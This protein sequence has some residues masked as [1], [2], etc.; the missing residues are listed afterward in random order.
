VII[1]RYITG[2]V[3]RPFVTIVAVIGVVFLSYSTAVVLND[4][5]AGLLPAHV[6]LQF[7][8]IKGLIALE[9]LIP[10]AL[11]LGVIAGL[12]RMQADSELT[13]LAASGVGEPSI[14]RIVFLFSLVVVLVVAFLSLFVRPWAYQQNYLLRAIAETEFEIEDLESRSFFVS[15]DLGFAIFADDVDPHARKAQGVLFQIRREQDLRIIAADELR[16]PRRGF[17]DPLSVYFLR[18]H[19]YQLDRAGSEDISLKFDRL[20]LHRKLPTPEDLGYKSKTQS[21]ARLASSANRKDLAEFQ[22]RLSTP[23]ATVLLAVLAVPMSRSTP[24]QG[25]HGRTIVALVVYAVF[26][27]LMSMAKNLVQEGI[28][29]AVPGLWW[30]LVLFS[31]G[32]A[33][34]LVGPA[35]RR[36]WKRR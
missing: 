16:Q 23:L 29:G 35:L 14:L 15:P 9:V 25:R 30:P 3:A 27:N 2:E 8:L 32:L 4:V 31:L 26:Y 11:Y 33:A 7:V 12:G 19:A 1:A 6:V 13:A 17:D 24:R 18:G 36:R 5:V 20:T 10:V 28:V 34:M 22:W 21:T